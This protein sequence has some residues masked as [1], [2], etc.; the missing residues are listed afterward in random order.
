MK[1]MSKSGECF[2]TW[3]VPFWFPI[4]QEKH[5]I[6][7]NLLDVELEILAIRRLSGGIL[8][9]MHRWTCSRNYFVHFCTECCGR[10]RLTWVF[11]LLVKNKIIFKNHYHLGN[12]LDIK[13]KFSVCK[14]TIF[15]YKS[16]SSFIGDNNR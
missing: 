3:G 11:R 14:W 4:Q 13:I 1:V 12:K 10:A 6:S 5:L 8:Y 9:T 2:D 7:L 15:F 16:G